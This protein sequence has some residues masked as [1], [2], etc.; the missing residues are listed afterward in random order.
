MQDYRFSPIQTRKQL[1]EAIHYVV[2]QT[3]ALAQ[4]VIG[5][6]FPITSVTIFAHYQNEYDNLVEIQ[7]KLG[8]FYNEN[9]GPRAVLNEPIIAGGNIITHLRI[10][11]PDPERPHV[12]CNDFETDYKLF[13]S[14]YLLPNLKG[15]RLIK[16]PNY[17]MIEF[18][19]PD[20]DVLAYVVSK[21]S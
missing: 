19:N 7:N 9:N 18:H 1:L 21:E 8:V 12:G 11:K 6:K 10:R 14:K 4:K 20:F 16:R 2:G 17:E 13:K 3:S 15:L 5:S